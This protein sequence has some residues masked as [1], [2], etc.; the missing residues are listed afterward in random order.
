[1]TQADRVLSTPPTNAPTSRRRF[2]STA[3]ALAA[4][5]AALAVA[6]PPAL[7]TDD[8]IFIAIEAHKAAFARVISAID[9]E[10]AAEAAT[11]KGMRK[12]DERYLESGEAVSAAW[13]AE[14]D[15]AIELVT[16]LPTTMTGVLALLDYAISADT[17]G[18]TWPRDLLS[19]DG[20]TGGSWH[21]F[22]IRNLT[23]ILPGLL[24]EMV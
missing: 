24:R 14:G 15:A 8:P 21:H 18:E 13:E 10:Q 7:A 9:V 22:L 19:D 11:P 1:M 23:E 12:T 20:E 17:D 3:A 16:V 6:I 5:G 4:G 2:L